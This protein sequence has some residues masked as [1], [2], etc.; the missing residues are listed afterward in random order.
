MQLLIRACDTCFWRQRRKSSIIRITKNV[1][2]SQLRNLLQPT[3]PIVGFPMGSTL[4]VSKKLIAFSRGLDSGSGCHRLWQCCNKSCGWAVSRL[5]N[6]VINRAI[7]FGCAY[8][9]SH[10]HPPDDPRAPCP[11]R[12]LLVL[13]L[14]R[15]LSHFLESSYNSNEL[16]TARPRERGMGCFVSSTYDD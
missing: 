6:C 12:I 9:T 4:N 5:E 7:N 8:F 1:I 11:F 10:I 15:H 14:S 3:L 16:P 13:M 2:G